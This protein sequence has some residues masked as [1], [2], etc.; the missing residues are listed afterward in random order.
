[1]PRLATANGRQYE[2]AG[3]E[4]AA[5]QALP[6]QDQQGEE[7]AGEAREVQQGERLSH[8]EGAVP[9]QVHLQYRL[10]AAAG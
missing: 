4:R 1:V 6:P 5:A 7:Q 8:G 9:Q 10:A 2:Q 3:L